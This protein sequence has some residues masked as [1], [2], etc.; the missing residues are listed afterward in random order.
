M[1]TAKPKR[2]VWK[3]PSPYGTYE[4][5][6][7]NPEQWRSAFSEVMT[8]EQAKEYLGNDSPWS[9]LGIAIGSAFDDIK[10]AFRRL[11]LKWHPDRWMQGSPEEQQKALDMFKKAKAA[12]VSLGGKD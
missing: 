3:D 9:I 1:K 4:G 5:D 6:R 12:Y 11:A 8:P 2:N 10:S 7:G